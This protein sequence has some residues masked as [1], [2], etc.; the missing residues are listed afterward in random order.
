MK[1]ILE[2]L[3]YGDHD[4]RFN[5]D[6]EV[7]K[8]PEIVLDLIPMI[9]FSMTTSLRGVKESNVIAVIRSLS[10]ADFTLCTNREE[11][12]KMLDHH[13]KILQNV[14]LNVT[15]DLENKGKAISFN[16]FAPHSKVVN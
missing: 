1:K 6:L 10:V 12:I 13:S 16:D 15:K 2:V 4:I 11:M 8:N 14:F 9:M 7:D 5:T 3:Q